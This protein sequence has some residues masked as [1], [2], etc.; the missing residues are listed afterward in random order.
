MLFNASNLTLRERAERRVKWRDGLAVLLHRFGE[1]RSA[2]F[3]VF[4]WISASLPPS[5]PPLPLPPRTHTRTERLLRSSHPVAMQWFYQ[6]MQKEPVVIW[7]CAI[8]F[9]GIQQ[10]SPPPS[11]I[12]DVA[13]TTRVFL[14]RFA[15]GSAA[16]PPP[17]LSS[18]GGGGSG[19][20]AS[21]W[22]A[23]GGSLSC[24]TL[25]RGQA[26]RISSAFFRDEILMSLGAVL[27]CS[28][29]DGKTKRCATSASG[30]ASSLSLARGRLLV[31][32]A[33][34][35]SFPKLA[36]PILTP[37]S[38]PPH[39]LALTSIPNS[40][41]KKNIHPTPFHTKQVSCCLWLCRPS[42]TC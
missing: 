12:R 19:C 14:V 26:H 37:A 3:P 9:T 10:P 8:G 28:F 7:S 40:F 2:L 11:D 1:R 29:R 15:K 35:R 16:L 4:F 6:A 36:P 42:G 5:P 38:P 32:F 25:H 13:H 21:K 30:S 34:S 31:V 18:R 24:G 27:M 41:P 39:H 22:T 20:G 17:P 33:P 23:A